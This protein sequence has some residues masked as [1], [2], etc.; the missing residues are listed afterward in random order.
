MSR[1]DLGLIPDLSGLEQPLLANFVLNTAFGPGVRPDRTT[2]GFLA[3][4]VAGVDK[5]VREYCAGRALLAEYANDGGFVSRVH[6]LGHFETCI[7][8]VKRSLRHIE[9]LSGHQPGPSID[10]SVRRLLSV[11]GK[12]ITPLRNAVEH[13]D[14]ALQEGT[15]PEGQ[16]HLLAVSHDGAV[17]RIA[18]HSL[19]F[20]ELA[21]LLTRM[22]SLAAEVIAPEVAPEAADA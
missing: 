4:Y 13:M 15:V 9:R 3:N 20:T 18:D 21:L 11:Y 12:K 14:E 6:A 16:P 2:F 7:N 19:A 8:S 1:M 22:H 17:L 5:A 10:R